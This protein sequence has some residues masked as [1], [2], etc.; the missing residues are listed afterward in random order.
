MDSRVNLPFLNFP[1]PRDVGQALP[2]LTRFSW[3]MWATWAQDE[4]SKAFVGHQDNTTRLVLMAQRMGERPGGTVPQVFS[5]PAERK[6][7]YRLLENKEVEWTDIA[8]A[9]HEACARRRQEH[10]WVIAILDGS[11]HSVTDPSHSHGTGP[12]GRRSLKGRGLKTMTLA[13]LTP[14]GQVLGI[15]AQ[16]PWV[17]PEVPQDVPAWEGDSAGQRGGRV[18]DRACPSGPV[19][20]AQG[21]QG[22]TRTARGERECSPVLEVEPSVRRRRVSERGL[23]ARSGDMSRGRGADRVGAMDN[24]YDRDGGR[25]RGG[26]AGLRPEVAGRASFYT[27][28]SGACWTEETQLESSGALAKWVVLQTS[29]AARRLSVMDR[30]RLEPQ[31]RASE[32]FSAEEIEAAQR[33]YGEE[34]R[35]RARERGWQEEPTLGDV[36]GWIASLGGYTGPSSGGQPGVV[37]IERGWERVTVGAKRLSSLKPEGLWPTSPHIRG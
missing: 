22:S 31:V 28:K 15:G 16:R 17:R 30:S 24:P 36:V 35:R 32:E 13:V 23:G 20:Q 19:D 29:V 21:A 26:T 1:L 2:A 18:P 11:S 33:L 7:A 34:N 25:R 9:R 6:G 8:Q 27:T 14:R 37:V 4:F 3:G 10:E 12:I 5:Y